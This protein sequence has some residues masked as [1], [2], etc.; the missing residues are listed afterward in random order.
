[1]IFKQSLPKL[2][3]ALQPCIGSVADHCLS[4]ELM[5]EETY[6]AI[7]ECNLTNADKSRRLLKNVRQT[8]SLKPDALDKFG[9]I[10]NE[11]EL[12]D[13]IKDIEQ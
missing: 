12:V 11:L 2:V 13:L 10:L 1:M 7:M 8:I 4:K 5:S 9:V 3:I 6:D